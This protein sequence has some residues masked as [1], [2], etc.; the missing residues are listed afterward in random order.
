MLKAGE[1]EL[2]AKI[3]VDNRP[4]AD[5]PDMQMPDVRV[6]L[7]RS[8]GALEPR[9]LKIHS[10]PVLGAFGNDYFTV[11]CR[12]NMPVPVTLAVAHLDAAGRPVSGSAARRYVLPAGLVHRFRVSKP[13]SVT[14]VRYRLEASCGERTFSTDTY[15]VR[16]PAFGRGPGPENT[17]RI[18]ALGDSRTNRAHWAVVARAVVREGPDLVVFTGDMVSRGRDEW[19]WEEHFF[20]PAREFFATI[21]H[22]P[23]IGNHEEKAPLYPLLFHTPGTDGLA[24]N[25]SQQ[26][27]DALLIG[28]EGRDDWSLDSENVRWLDGVLSNSRAGF[29]F[30]FSHYPAYTSGTHGELDP[31]TGRPV[32]YEVLAGQSVI[33]PLLRKYDAT[34][35]IVGHDHLYER[36]ELPG[37]LT[38]IISGGAGAPLRGKSLYAAEQNPYSVKFASRL[39]YCVL[40][41]KGDA[42]TM[43]AV[44]VNGRTLDTRTWKAR[45]AAD[46]SG[47][48]PA[49][50]GE[51]LRPAA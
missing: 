16:L 21:P 37:G 30:L 29:I 7:A 25:W 14:N 12:T 8:L 26:I 46:S 9:H 5:Y 41:I 20:S 43:R 23:V 32:E 51:T 42:C 10:G 4:P 47:R 40:E 36:S 50:R 11:T 15:T 13:A 38:H 33:V 45:R 17:L 34:A 28:I 3:G 35:M 2:T 31:E 44:A 19:Q 18:A 6:R 1:N 48:A 49:G 22:Y 39:H 27:G 24:K